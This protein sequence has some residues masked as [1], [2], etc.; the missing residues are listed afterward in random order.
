MFLDHFPDVAAPGLIF[1]LLTLG[2]LA[3]L[4]IFVL[5]VFI[6]TVVLQLMRWGSFK[7]SLRASFYM[8]LV[9]TLF[10]LAALFLI[11][12]WPVAGLLISW[13]L[14][15]LIE[16]LVLKRLARTENMSVWRISVVAN[17][18][19]YLLLIFPAYLFSR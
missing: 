14:S 15:I 18:A 6:E 8:N 5:I 16:G 12:R 17:L 4:I 13:G 2:C 10:G 11:T 3:L 1:V 7:S 9:S 19:S